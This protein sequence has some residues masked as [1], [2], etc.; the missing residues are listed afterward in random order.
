MYSVFLGTFTTKY[1]VL[2]CVSTVMQIHRAARASSSGEQLGRAARASSSGE[3]LGRAKNLPS[4][5]SERAARD[6]QK[7]KATSCT[8]DLHDRGNAALGAVYTCPILSIIPCTICI[9][10]V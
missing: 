7:W 2:S 3:Q 1:D 6:G 9:Q 5:S 4:P 8:M 10:G